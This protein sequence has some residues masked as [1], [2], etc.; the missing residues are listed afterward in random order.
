MR[1]LISAYRANPTEKNRQ[2]LLAYANKHPFAMILLMPDDQQL[3][4]S[5]V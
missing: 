4:A 1:K 3:I 5:L 2:R